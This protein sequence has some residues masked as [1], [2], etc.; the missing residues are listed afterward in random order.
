ML[1]I[2]LKA[3]SIYHNP[4]QPKTCPINLCY[5]WCMPVTFINLRPAFP[6]ARLLPW[7]VMIISSATSTASSWSWVTK[8]LVIPSCVTILLSH[9]SQFRTNLCINGGKRFIKQEAPVDLELMLLQKQLFVS[10]RRTSWFGY[11]F[12]IPESPVIS[13]KFRNPF[14]YICFFGTFCKSPVQMPHYRIPSY[15]GTMRNF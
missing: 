2:L 14:S 15:I 7:F 4:Q 3:C 13:K 12:S 8:I 9:E 1:S 10:V 11:R 5:K 6:S